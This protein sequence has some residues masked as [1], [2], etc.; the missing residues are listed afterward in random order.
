MS[1]LITGHQQL[2]ADIA[3]EMT[4]AGP[5]TFARFM[6]IALYH[7][8]FGYYMRPVGPEEERIGWSGD[9]YTSSD[10]HPFLGEAL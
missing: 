3:S 7:P 4:R 1:L 5:M 2:I 8:Q 6:E 9:F 10:V